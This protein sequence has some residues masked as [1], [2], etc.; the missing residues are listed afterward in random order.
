MRKGLTLMEIIISVTIL[1]M[2]M[3]GFLSI[4]I[5]ARRQTKHSRARTTAA[6]IARNFLEPLHMQVR[7]DEWATNCLG[8]GSNCPSSP[9]NDVTLDS[10]T[11]RPTLTISNIAGTT[12]KKARIRI[13][14]SE[15]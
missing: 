8:S 2:L 1:S 13:D 3:A 15:N 11:Y 5:S 10:I 14:W 7:Q 6:E 4:F 12:L 9:A